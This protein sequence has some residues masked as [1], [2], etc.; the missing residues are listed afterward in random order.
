MSQS[1]YAVAPMPD[2][3][4]SSTKAV[5][6]VKSPQ[7]HRF[8]TKAI[9]A[10]VQ[11]DPIT[12]AVTTPISLATTFV[13]KSPGVHT[14]YEYSRTGNPT[15]AA[16][17]ANIAGIENARYGLAFASGSAA[18]VT[19]INM[20]SSGDHVITVDDVYGGT[21]RYFNRVATPANNMS[22]S[23]VDF[24]APGAIEAAITPKTKLM[25][26]E[27][28]T[29]PTLKVVDIR[30]AARIA[31]QHNIICVVDNT[32][33][34][35]YLQNPL[36]LGADIVVHSVTKYLGG[37]SDCVMGVL[38]TNREDIYT[39]LKFLQNA[40]GA[41]PAPFDCYMALR[42]VKTLHLRMRQHCSNAMAVAKFLES[43]PLVDRVLYPGLP[44]H[45]QHNI[46]KSQMRDFGGMVTF[47][48]KGGIDES[49]AFL[50][51]LDLFALAESLGAVESLAEHPAIMTHAAVPPEQRKLLGISDSLIRLS[52]GVEDIEDIL[53]DLKHALS[54]VALPK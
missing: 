21:N 23:M 36:D 22:F 32:F 45:P 27:T 28:P 48:I 6:T 33:A 24:C 16:F 40:I 20:L 43:H 51:N 47:F 11:P 5:V 15:R 10:G 26:I 2:D 39:K 52:V 38:A 31:K 30:N 25:W 34:S 8:G 46:A 54:K 14:G 35:P 37:H 41:V 12:G 50:E 18:T 49:R 42:G 1:V 44:S 53:D 19:I 29:N 3:I 13:Q 4:P 17:E 7:G 9:H